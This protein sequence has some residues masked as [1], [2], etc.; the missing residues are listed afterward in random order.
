MF[1]LRNRCLNIEEKQWYIFQFYHN[2]ILLLKS[3]YEAE[4]NDT[5]IPRGYPPYGGKIAWARH[6]YRQVVNLKDTN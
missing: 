3:I 2:E 1:Q 6:L 4:K 5:P